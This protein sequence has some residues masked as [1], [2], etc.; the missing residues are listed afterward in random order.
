MIC[1]FLISRSPP[2]SCI[3]DKD[4]V[5][6]GIF[7]RSFCELHCNFLDLATFQDSNGLCIDIFDKHSPACFGFAGTD[8]MFRFEVL[9]L[10]FYLQSHHI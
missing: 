3:L 1:L 9:L 7:P 4:F 10:A 8:T 2:T 5:G 6:G